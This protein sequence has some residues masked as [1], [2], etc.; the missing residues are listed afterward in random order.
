MRLGKL[1]STAVLGV[2]SYDCG[3]HYS[4]LQELLSRPTPLISS[5]ATGNAVT[6]N[7][8]GARID[9]FIGGKYRSVRFNWSLSNAFLKYCHP[10]APVGLL[11]A[12]Q[13]ARC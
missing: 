10:F 4:L 1:K 12:P 2:R 8:R 13:L 3:A 9:G 11:F 5:Q 6:S 7:I